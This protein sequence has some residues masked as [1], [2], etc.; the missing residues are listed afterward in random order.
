MLTYLRFRAVAN[1]TRCAFSSSSSAARRSQRA[2]RRLYLMVLAILV[3][4]FPV[5]A[6][7]AALNVAAALPLRP[8]DF[9]R[10]HAA[11]AHPWLWNSVVVAP[12]DRQGWVYLNSCYIP[13]LAAVP[14][15]VFF[16]TTTDAVNQYRLLLLRLG[17]ARL[18]PGLEREYDPDRGSAAQ[19]STGSDCAT[20]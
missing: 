1:A 10:V 12:A 20:V 5:V 13:V 14:V 8:F 4:Y 16:G 3:P 6:G 9:A 17:L 7:L 19:R 2:R 11:A 15:F 18:F